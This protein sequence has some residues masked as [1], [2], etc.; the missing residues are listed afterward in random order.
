MIE[1]MS[2]IWLG[3]TATIRDSTPHLARLLAGPATTC[4]AG[5]RSGRPTL[6]N[7]II[8]DPGLFTIDRRP[9]E[10]VCPPGA[11]VGFRE[12][13][14][15]ITATVIGGVAPTVTVPV[16]TSVAGPQFVEVRASDKVGKERVLSDEEGCEVTVGYRF[17]GFREP[18]SADKLN[19]VKPARRCPS[20][21]ASP[22]RTASAST[23]RRASERCGSSPTPARP[24]H[25]LQIVDN[26]DQQHRPTEAK[27]EGGSSPTHSL[28]ALTADAPPLTVAPAAAWGLPASVPG[29]RH[30][31]RVDLSQPPPHPA[32]CRSPRDAFWN[33][34]T[35]PD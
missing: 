18:I 30:R 14:A 10:I 9:P 28:V 17:D 27:R 33:P 7:G 23:T 20:S 13:G 19:N 12:V 6:C 11:G 4:P 2:P 21:G 34:A 24:D 25:A 8:D 22:M 29:I 3:P 5:H 31:S 1:P 15:T 26:P 35:I 32:A 16:D